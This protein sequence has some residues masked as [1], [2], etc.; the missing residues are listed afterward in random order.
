MKKVFSVFLLLILYFGCLYAIGVE[1]MSV[2]IEADAGASAEFILTI[3]GEAQD[4]VTKITPFQPLQ[5]ETGDITYQ[6]VDAEVYSPIGWIS[7]DQNEVDVPAGGKTDIPVKVNI[8]FGIRG[9][10]ILTLMVEPEAA[11]GEGMIQFKIRY[12]VRVT[13]RVNSS[14]IRENAKVDAMQFVPNEKKAPVL[15]VKLNNVSGLDYLC[16]VN[17]S[18][19]DETG[20]LIENLKMMTDSEQKRGQQG[21][22]FYP[23]A[24][25]A[26]LSLPE[27]IVSPGKYRIQAIVKM[28]DFQ[29]IFQQTVEIKKDEFIFPDARDF[30]LVIDNTK[31]LLQLNPGGVKTDV[32]QAS[33]ESQQSI[34]VSVQFTDVVSDFENSI[35]Y[36]VS[37]RGEPKFTLDPGR[38]N[39]LVTMYKIPRDATPNTYYGKLIYT[40]SKDGTPITSETVTM[41]VQIGEKKTPSA[42]LSNISSNGEIVAAVLEN[43]GQVHLADLLGEISVLRKETNE[44]IS[45]V[46]VLPIDNSWIF[47]TQEFS[48]IGQPETPIPTGTMIY[49]LMLYNGKDL[50][51]ETETEGIIE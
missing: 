11:Q 25:L 13:I 29:R 5:Q 2:E 22:R 41:A 50:I 16:S 20:R 27:K 45:T 49:R 15:Q 47:P 33:N 9:T 10:Y 48:L 4:T 37:F 43:D 24:S 19:R 32:I 51:L 17:A 18:I 14:G 36:F 1:P 30:Y 23:E 31:R 39:R 46:E 3:R 44:M 40:A 42:T 38:S 6:Q 8:P 34:D 7:L 21:I 12:A 35:K 28:N 26:F